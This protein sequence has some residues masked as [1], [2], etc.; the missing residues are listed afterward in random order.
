MFA[1]SGGQFHR[2]IDGGR[3]SGGE[4]DAMN[5]VLVGHTPEHGD[6]VHDRGE[7]RKPVADG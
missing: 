7:A 1:V 4:S 6:L 3:A 2:D 5:G